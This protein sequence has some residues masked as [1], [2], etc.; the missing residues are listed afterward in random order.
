[1][2]TNNKKLYNAEVNG[3][4]ISE[5][6]LEMLS[7]YYQSCKEAEKLLDNDMV[8]NVSLAIEMGSEIVRKT[9]KAVADSCIPETI[10]QIVLND[11]FDICEK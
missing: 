9:K 8:D 5:T 4:K 7:E 6:E 11:Y 2:K 3:K 10:Q 1:M